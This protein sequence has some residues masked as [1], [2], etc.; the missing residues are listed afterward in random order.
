MVG[1]FLGSEI[2]KGMYMCMCVNVCKRQRLE[3]G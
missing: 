2:R 1:T 3:S